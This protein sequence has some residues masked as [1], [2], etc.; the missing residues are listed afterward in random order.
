[1]KSKDIR[2]ISFQNLDN[3]YISAFFVNGESDSPVAFVKNTYQSFIAIVLKTVIFTTFALMLCQAIWK[4]NIY[5][6][7][8]RLLKI[9]NKYGFRL[10]NRFREFSKSFTVKDN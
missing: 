4:I 2:G 6:C 5:M 10:A 7:T 1:M 3:F 8:F 9:N